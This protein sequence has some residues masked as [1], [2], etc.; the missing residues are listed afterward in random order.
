MHR[1]GGVS[2]HQGAN[3][4]IGVAGNERGLQIEKQDAAVKES[5]EGKV[6]PGTNSC[7]LEKEDLGQI[8]CSVFT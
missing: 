3:E 7:T 5:E 8:W 2:A 6:L 1:G 4:D